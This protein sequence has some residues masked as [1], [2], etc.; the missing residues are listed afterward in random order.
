VLLEV[1]DAATSTSPKID[2]IAVE[3]KVNPAI[4]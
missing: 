1:A 4:G 3:C 2:I